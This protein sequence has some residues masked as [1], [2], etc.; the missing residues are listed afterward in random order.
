MKLH[1]VSDLHLEGNFDAAHPGINPVLDADILVLAGDIA[2]GARATKLFARWPRPVLYVHG[3]LEAR[4]GHLIDLS[5]SIRMQASG[6]NVRYLE[7]ETYVVG[8][9][10]FVASCLWTDYALYGAPSS[11]MKEAA[12]CMPEFA[13]YR[14]GDNRAFSPA[15]A[16]KLHQMA[17]AWLTSELGKSFDGKTVVLTH[18]APH[19]KSIPQ[20]FA[21]DPLSPAFASDLSSLMQH[22]DLW[23]HGHVHESCDYMVGTCRVVCNPRGYRRKIRAGENGAD[24]NRSFNP[25]LVIAI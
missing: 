13:H 1:V 8:D 5:R 25:N 4:S 10:R 9:V 7:M 11:A 24:E 14:G 19:A 15:Y 6:T 2:R 17:R 21:G 16:L 3:N 22:A 23:V 12:R 18:H 20:R